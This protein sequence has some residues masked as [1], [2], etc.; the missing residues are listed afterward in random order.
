MKASTGSYHCIPDAGPGGG[1]VCRD[2][3]LAPL[4]TP[5]R[6]VIHPG[7]LVRI[8]LGVSAR[9]VHVELENAAQ[10]ELRDLRRPRQ[11]DENGQYF[12]LRLPDRLPRGSD[13]FH[14][15]VEPYDGNYGD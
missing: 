8:R 15:F 14:L 1:H 6:L 11:T 12:N 2:R 3:V 13:R 7:G 4:R 5:T 9:R 10:E